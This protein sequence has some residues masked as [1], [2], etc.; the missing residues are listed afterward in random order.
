[1]S[2]AVSVGGGIRIGAGGGVKNLLLAV[3]LSVLS[4]ARVRLE[5]VLCVGSVSIEIFPAHSRGGGGGAWV[6]EVGVVRVVFSARRR[7][8]YQERISHCCHMDR[9]DT[10]DSRSCRQ[11]PCFHQHN[12]LPRYPYKYLSWIRRGAVQP[13]RALSNSRLGWIVGASTRRAK[14]VKSSN[15]VGGTNSDLLQIVLSQQLTN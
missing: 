2:R 11:A 14:T 12:R 10:V 13:C 15:R 9:H 1:M 4:M 7:S 6:E 5:T 3:N 8:V